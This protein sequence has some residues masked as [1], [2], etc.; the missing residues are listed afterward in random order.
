MAPGGIVV[1]DQDLGMTS[2]EPVPL[3][4]GVRPGRYHMRRV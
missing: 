3:P 4:P 2:S 1:S